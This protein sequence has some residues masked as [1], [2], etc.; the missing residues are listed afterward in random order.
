MVP[1]VLANQ[2]VWRRADI[3]ED[4]DAGEV[5]C[6]VFRIRA[7]AFAGEVEPSKAAAANFFVAVFAR[8]RLNAN[9]YN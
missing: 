7:D 3:L 2:S 1:D 5:R 9:A 4:D 8:R 6:D